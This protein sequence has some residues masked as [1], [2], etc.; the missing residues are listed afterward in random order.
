M[1]IIKWVT[2]ETLV[3]VA[4]THLFRMKAVQDEFKIVGW[5]SLGIFYKSFREIFL[6]LLAFNIISCFLSVLVTVYKPLIHQ[7][8]LEY[9]SVQIITI[10]ILI[11]H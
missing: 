11:H 4:Y 9:L 8:G 2:L 3:T 10:I 7:V 6:V 1:I 5:S